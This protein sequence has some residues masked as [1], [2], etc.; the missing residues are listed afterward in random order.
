MPDGSTTYQLNALQIRLNDLD[1]INYN[2]LQSIVK[3][4]NEFETC[5]ELLDPILPSVI[6]NLTQLFLEGDYH[7]NR[8]KGLGTIVYTLAKVRGFKVL[9]TFFSS[10]VYMVVKIL[11][12]LLGELDENVV[13]LN[14]LWLTNLVLVP[15][16]FQTEMIDSFFHVSSNQLGKYTNGSKNQIC[17]L[18]LMARFLS[19]PDLILL[20]Y[21]Q[22][23]FDR[24]LD[25]WDSWEDLIK[26]GHLM[27]VN[28]LFKTCPQLLSPWISRIY[29]HIIQ[30][31]LM[32]MKMGKLNNLNILFVVKVSSKLAQVF[33]DDG[34]Y[35]MIEQIINNLVNDV[36]LFYNNKI[37]TTLRYA[38]AKGLGHIAKKLA[39]VAN[40]QQQ[41]IEF[42]IDQLALEVDDFTGPFRDLDVDLSRVSATS[43]HTVLLFL[44]Y[45]A[46]YKVLP[47][48]LYPTIFSIIHKTLFVP[49]ILSNANISSQ[50]KDSSCFV[51]WAM[52]RDMNTSTYLEMETQ[53]PTL[54]PLLF[55][56][57]LEVS[58]FDRDLII[59]RC[60]VAVLQEFIGRLGNHVIKTSDPVLKGKQTISLI[61]LFSSSRISTN[62]DSILLVD[63]LLELGISKN[64]IIDMILKNIVKNDFPFQKQLSHKLNQILHKDYAPIFDIGITKKEQL[65][66]GI[67]NTLMPLEHSLYLISELELNSKTQGFVSS[68]PASDDYIEDTLQYVLYLCESHQTVDFPEVVELIVRS[69]KD[70]TGNLK[71]L[72]RSMSK[73]G[74]GIND[75]L[76]HRMLHR[77]T[78]SVSSAI[79]Y[80][81]I[82]TKDQ[83]QLVLDMV[84]NVEIDYEIRSNLIKC[85]HEVYLNQPFLSQDQVWQFV[86]VLNDYTTTEQGDVGSKLRDATLDFIE[87][88]YGLFEEA[89]NLDYHLYR[90]IG[91]PIEKLRVK[92]FAL[93]CRLKAW[94]DSILSLDQYY[95]TLFKIYMEIG[96]SDKR[97][98]FWSGI[99]HSIGGLTGE[100]MNIRES[101]KQFN[102]FISSLNAVDRKQVYRDLLQVITKQQAES[103]RTIKGY[104][105]GLNLMIK[106]FDSNTPFPKDLLF[107]VFVKAYNL[108]INCTNVTRIKLTL[109]L[110]QC[111][112]LES[113]PKAFNASI[114]RLAAVH[115]NHKSEA[116]RDFC[117]EL[118]YDIL[119]ELDDPKYMEIETDNN[120]TKPVIEYVLKKFT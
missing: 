31:E 25:D 66:I 71:H 75:E 94:D 78:T 39:P 77:I 104:I 41:M 53:N 48:C 13:F 110:M 37:E 4:I 22:R 112:T 57:L 7:G 89:D 1:D 80:L 86:N 38:L 87:D 70:I 101:F 46:L 103:S 23:Y 32:R 2:T 105:H 84:Y 114:K 16:P 17:S 92:A 3:L 35:N 76:L 49:K 91:E 74:A 42:L 30:L 18:I 82:L 73:N 47:L 40:Y 44:G 59:R 68:I 61:E 109:K 10:D 95:H 117:L 120:N 29:T 14:L 45:T 118:I 43:C 79:F 51:L 19:R 102:I 26:L 11:D 107:P 33:V 9:S 97:F 99:V 72:F 65:L 63:N 96:E 119:L 69:K 34:D 90:I 106:V 36:L 62:Q 6:A 111:L 64:F 5:P 60:G 98:L 24:L 8:A 21:L 20:G 83:V 81:T 58:I 108:Q 15:F 52:V 56:D 113:D 55:M 115:S 28:K 12:I 50:I 27:V 88:N 100:S 85:A 93:L 116:V 54:F 67:K